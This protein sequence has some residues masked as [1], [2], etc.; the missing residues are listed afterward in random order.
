MPKIDFRWGTQPAFPT[1]PKY[2][3][4]ASVAVLALLVAMFVLVSWVDSHAQETHLDGVESRIRADVEVQ[5]QQA[6]YR[7]CHTDTECEVC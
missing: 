2:E 5:A 4:A 3:K 6:C 1:P 7:A